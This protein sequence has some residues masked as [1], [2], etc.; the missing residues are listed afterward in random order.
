MWEDLPSGPD[1]A[2]QITTILYS[3]ND[4][5][6]GQ[7][8]SAWIPAVPND[9]S[10]LNIEGSIIESLVPLDQNT[11]YSHNRKLL[12]GSSSQHEWALAAA[13][14]ATVH[15]RH[16][17]DDG[18]NLCE[19][20]GLTLNNRAYALGYTWRASG[21]NLPLD[22]GSEPINVQM[23]AFQSISV[24]ADPTREMKA[25]R[26]GFG[27][28]AYLLY[29]QFGPRPLL[30]MGKEY[31]TELDAGTISQRLRDLFSTSGEQYNL[32]QDAT[33]TVAGNSGTEW[34]I[35]QP[36]LPPLY[37]LQLIS[38]DGHST[39]HVLDYAGGRFLFSLPSRYQ[40]QL[41]VGPVSN[42]VRAAFS[43]ANVNL[44][45]PPDATIT[46]H[47]LTAE[48][49]IGT[50]GAQ[51]Y[52][53]RRN[54]DSIEV[55]HYPAP[56]FSPN[57]FYLDPR[58]GSGDKNYHVRHVDLAPDAEFDYGTD[59]SWGTFVNA[60]LDAAVV[61]PSGYIVGVSYDN[62]KMEILRLPEQP[63]PAKEAQ[64]ASLVSGL[65]VREGLMH[66]PVALTVTP[67][68][69]I[70][71]LERDNARIQAFDIAGNAVQCFTGPLSIT[72][73]P[74]LSGFLDQNNGSALSL[75]AAYQ[76][77]VPAQTASMFVLTADSVASL[78]AGGMSSA[79]RQ[80]FAQHGLS[81]ANDNFEINV[82]NQGSLWLAKN[83][84]KNI[85][86]DIR[87]N[88]SGDELEVFQAPTLHIEVKIPGHSWILRDKLSATVFE[89]DINENRLRL[90]QLIATM[91]LHDPPESNITYLDIGV[92]TK[93]FIYVLSYA[94][95]GSRLSDY[96]LDLY[97][98][99][100]T[101]L[102]RTP[103]DP[104]APGVNAAKLAIDQ[105]RSV[106]TLNFEQILGPGGQT[107][108]SISRWIPST[109]QGQAE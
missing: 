69:R 59:T 12:T 87:R 34:T 29:D 66:G 83:T 82:T 16:C 37:G 23:Y 84:T 36:A 11:E 80:Q 85:L 107:E 49:Y 61:H 10:N 2:I 100:G 60:K 94:G 3:K 19:L 41:M 33:V 108:P 81:V 62:H 64:P 22:H 95:T 7:W 76:L 109:P 24:L 26:R 71:V 39:I 106:Y 98:P 65:G 53:L 89:I 35:G 13:P 68:G 67:D 77:S 47:Q 17:T 4:W 96:H 38:H 28:P 1:E 91:P 31:Q 101:H 21:Q 104:N 93:S 70:L 99:D 79:V 90:R 45:L 30:S 42:E 105:W 56:A 44:S 14:T 52:D 18:H 102:S 43:S 63:V 6:A 55:F 86:F 97:N 20:T 78:D 27:R 57:N 15:D 48:W 72:L 5:I 9:G 40:Q 51:L 73:D 46:V 92:E 54:V 74:G 32:S 88:N 8:V 58:D 25:P 50:P 75:Q 103:K